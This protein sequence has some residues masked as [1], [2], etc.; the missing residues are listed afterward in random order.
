METEVYWNAVRDSNNKF[1]GA[2]FYGV[3][4][5]GIYCKPSC[6]ARL[7]KREN[8]RFFDSTKSAESSGFRACLRCR[9]QFEKDNSQAEM[10]IRACRIIERI[11]QIT[12]KDLGAELKTS[13][14]HLQKIFKNLIGVSPKK[15]AVARRMERFKAGL[16]GGK[17]VTDAMYESGFGSS[18]RLYDNVSEKLGMTPRVYEKGGID[19]KIEYTIAET[20]LGLMLVARTGRGICAVAFGETEA[21]LADGLSSEYRTAETVR[22]DARLKEFV[23]AILANLSGHNKTLDLPLDLRAT[24]FQMRVWEALKKIPYGETVSYQTIAEQ[25]GNQNAVRAVAGAC[26]ANRVA[27]VIPCHR[28]V[29][30][31]GSLSGYKW[32]VD[33]K[34]EILENERDGVVVKVHSS[35]TT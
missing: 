33:R 7:P 9:P 32:G 23:E 31:D 5:T 21:E 26:A 12:L 11:E 3:S 35:G 4:S 29:R 18:S 30:S 19:L 25:L 16:R 14:S 8:V 27:L 28:V 15:Y 2:F 22:N 13:P 10:V 20:D 24:A 1:N 6:G 34:K 17:N